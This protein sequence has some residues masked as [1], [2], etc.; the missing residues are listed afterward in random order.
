MTDDDWR[1]IRAM[2]IALALTLACAAIVA[3]LVIGLA[4]LF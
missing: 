3:T 1:E 2:L 4:F